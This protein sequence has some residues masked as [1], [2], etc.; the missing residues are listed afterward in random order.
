M[1]THIFAGSSQATNA[2]VVPI[3]LSSIIVMIN[4]CTVAAIIGVVMLRQIKNKYV[5]QHKK[6]CV[7]VMTN[8]TSELPLIKRKSKY[9]H[10]TIFSFHLICY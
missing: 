3:V 9:Y 1:Y 5:P 10:I 8:S 6:R 2:I 7:H 4:T